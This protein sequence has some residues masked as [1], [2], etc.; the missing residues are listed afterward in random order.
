MV[1]KSMKEAFNNK[2]RMIYQ[3]SSI[4]NSCMDRDILGQTFAFHK[5]R[6]SIRIDV[7]MPY[8][9]MR[10]EYD[11]IVNILYLVPTVPLGTVGTR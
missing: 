4:G 2:W 9:D 8:H 1:S 7:H 3:F 5:R 6:F 11:S 10:K